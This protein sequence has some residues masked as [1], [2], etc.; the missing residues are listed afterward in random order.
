MIV[1]RDGD[2]LAGPPSAIAMGVFDGLHR[3]HQRVISEVIQLAREHDAV[4]TVV[5]FDPHPAEVL[6]EGGAPLMLSTIDQRLEGL[7]AL[8]V[9]HTRVLTFDHSLA[10]ESA[11][12]F[13]DRVLARELNARQVVV[14]SNFRFGHDRVG[15]V[16]LLEREGDVR[17]FR[18]HPA[19]LYGDGVRWSSTA[20]R[21]ALASGDLARA[22]TVLGR[23]FTLRGEVEH[24]DARGVGLGFPTANV[25]VARRQ[26]LPAN[27]IYAGAARARDATWWPAAISVG[28]RPQ[29]YDDGATLVEVHLVGFGGDLYSETLDV[30]FAEAL[31]GEMSF[32]DVDELIEQIG[33]DV[34]QTLAIFDS[35][36]AE[37]SALLG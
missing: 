13:V 28:T 37:S 15:D 23:P 9:E 12:S 27:G 5:T 19:P 14:G 34:K 24:G 7:A 31:R 1:T 29:F 21:V 8:G 35:F 22:N 16:A 30:A 32:A 18:V 3:G 4:P 20:V 6:S 33:R 10:E 36:S 17:G 26:Q 25:A 11:V 2:S